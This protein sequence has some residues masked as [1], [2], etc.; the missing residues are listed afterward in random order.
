MKSA[1]YF[2][3]GSAAT[4]E[5]SVDILLGGGI[6]NPHLDTVNLQPMQLT[7][8][9]KDDLLAFL[10]SLDVNYDIAMPTLP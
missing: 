10:R 2:H 9:E 1:P 5:E 7:A 6:Q 3:D 4:L 8:A